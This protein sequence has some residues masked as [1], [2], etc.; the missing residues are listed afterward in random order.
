MRSY[1]LPLSYIRSM[2]IIQIVLL[3]I[4]LYTV[5]HTMSVH[6][7]LLT[8]LHTYLFWYVLKDFAS[9]S[10]CMCTKLVQQLITKHV[11]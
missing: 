9:F 1:T 8:Y 6:T 11:I 7:Y 5:V 4:L 3:Y 10:K 2:I